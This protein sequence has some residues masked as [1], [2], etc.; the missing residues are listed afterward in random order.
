MMIL[1]PRDAN[2][3]PTLAARRRA[4]LGASAR[5]LNVKPI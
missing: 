5:R 2:R 3:E 4:H 1:T